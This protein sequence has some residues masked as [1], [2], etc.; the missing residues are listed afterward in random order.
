MAG[1]TRI[2]NE[3]L[4]QPWALTEDMMAVVWDVLQFRARGGRLTPDEIRA[5]IGGDE[6]ANPSRREARVMRPSSGGGAAIAVVPIYGVIAHR[7]FERS[8]GMTSAE[9]IAN[10]V[11]QAVADPE[12]GTIVLDIASPGGTVAGTTETADQIYRARKSKRVVAVANAK[13]ASA[14]YWMASQ[15]SEVVITPSGSAGSIGVFSLHEDW[16]KW[17]EREGVA[18]TPI[19]AGRRKLEGAPWAPLDD[20]AK[21]HFQAAVDG[22]YQ[23]FTAA[24]ARGRG[25]TVADVRGERFGEGRAFE[26]ADALKRGLVDS[27]ETF[28]QVIARILSEGRSGG[29]ARAADMGAPAMALDPEDLLHVEHEHMA[30]IASIGGGD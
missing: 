30:M 22:A 2:V 19:Q 20:E 15:A 14:A 1:Y 4:R 17:L 5:R 11:A 23:Q 13:A 24:V 25:V 26:A 29:S 10:G 21:A 12:V 9:R 27:I 6:E 3:A 28:D 7:E 8:S 16:S 18:I